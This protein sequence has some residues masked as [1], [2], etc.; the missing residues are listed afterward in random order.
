MFDA[1]ST[2]ADAMQAS[3][4]LRVIDFANTLKVPNAQQTAECDHEFLFGLQQLQVFLSALSQDQEFPWVQR[5]LHKPIDPE[6]LDRELL[7]VRA[8]TPSTPMTPQTPGATPLTE[9]HSPD[10]LDVGPA[11]LG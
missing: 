4:R 3:A 2:D 1:A 10:P 9:V 11:A 6:V 8:A 5:N 7:H